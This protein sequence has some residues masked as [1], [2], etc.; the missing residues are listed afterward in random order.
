MRRA[1]KELPPGDLLQLADLLAHGRLAESEASSGGGKVPG[2]GDGEKGPEKF[3]IHG[4]FT[5]WINVIGEISI[6]NF[7]SP[8][9]LPQPTPAA[10]LLEIDAASA[11]LTGRRT[12]ILK[13]R[14]LPASHCHGSYSIHELLLTLPLLLQIATGCAKT[15]VLTYVNGQPGEV[16]THGNVI[17]DQP[18]AA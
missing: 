3:D 7:P 1:Q 5:R 17:L 11:A 16:V 10:F 18:V 4:P 14:W 8:R 15:A 9:Q 13:V 2:L 6:A 12:E